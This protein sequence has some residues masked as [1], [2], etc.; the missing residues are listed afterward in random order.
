KL[1]T[2][3]GTY[4]LMEING[5]LWGS[6]QLAID[7]GVDFPVL[8]VEAALGLPSHP[9]TKYRVG[10]RS[11]WEWGDVDHLLALLFH[12]S[13]RLA[14]PSRRPGRLVAIAGFLKALRRGTQSEVLRLSD[15]LPFIRETVNWIFGR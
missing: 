13:N 1:D 14:L 15:P 2:N 11:Q 12:S 6:L 3:T 4:Y 8:L 5:R 9:V 10:I 7:S